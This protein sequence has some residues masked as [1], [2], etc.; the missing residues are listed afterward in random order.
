LFQEKKDYNYTSSY[1]SLN[2]EGKLRW[3]ILRKFTN[4]SKREIEDW[5][6]CWVVQQYDNENTSGFPDV[7]FRGHNYSTFI[8]LVQQYKLHIKLQMENKIKNVPIS[9]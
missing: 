2:P 3:K 8:Q 4:I 9:Q 6:Y 7:L 5:R 1:H